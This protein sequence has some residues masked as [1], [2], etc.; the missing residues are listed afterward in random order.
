M[1]NTIIES[2]NKGF[3]IDHLTRNTDTLWE[4]VAL[5]NQFDAECVSAYAVEVECTDVHTGEKLLVKDTPVELEYPLIIVKGTEVE[6]SGYAVFHLT[7]KY[8]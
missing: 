3:V 4:C 1:S 8:I 2:D 5:G 7:F 6:V